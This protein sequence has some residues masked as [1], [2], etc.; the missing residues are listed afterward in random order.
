LLL[1]KKADIEKSLSNLLKALEAGI[2]SATIQKRMTELEDEK[3]E[4][5]ISIA[6]EE[7]RTKKLDE[8]QVLNFLHR[9][10]DGDANDINYRRQ[11]IDCFVNRIYLFD[12]RMVLTFNTDSDTREISFDLVKGS[13]MTNGAPPSKKVWKIRTFF[14][15][16]R[17]ILKPCTARF[18]TRKLTRGR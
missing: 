12:D 5:E 2:I 4:I 1:R 11:L 18:L 6:K 13:D 15:F 9:F 8:T 3:S 17:T 14:Y 10:K 7:L 16:P